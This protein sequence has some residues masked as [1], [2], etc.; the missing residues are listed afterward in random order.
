VDYEAHNAIGSIMINLGDLEQ[1]RQHISE[2][3]RLKP[4]YAAARQNLQ[5]LQASFGGTLKNKP[6]SRKM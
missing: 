4:G 2:A 1:A 6:R 3:L 5:Q